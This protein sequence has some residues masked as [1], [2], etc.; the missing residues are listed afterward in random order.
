MDWL[1]QYSDPTID[2]PYAMVTL[3]VRFIGVFLV[4]AVMQV[5]LQIA[6]RAVGFIESRPARG[7]AKP[8]HEAVA[9]L[10][11]SAMA[12]AE[13]DQSGAVAA[14]IGLALALEEEAALSRAAPASRAPTGPSPWAMT[15]RMQQLR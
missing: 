5:A 12:A 15:G 13:V 4:M 9:S 2:W 10:D 8:H 3:I 7:A 6:A 1:F 11:L 14:A